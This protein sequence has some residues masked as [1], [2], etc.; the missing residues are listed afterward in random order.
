MKK[1]FGPLTIAA[2]IGFIS[3]ESQAKGNMSGA[4]G[5]GYAFTSRHTALSVN[6][7][8]LTSGDSPMSLYG[9]YSFGNTFDETSDDIIPAAFTGTSGKVG[10]GVATSYPLAD[11]SDP[12]YSGGLGFLLGTLSLGFSVD[13][14]SDTVLNSGLQL[15]LGSMRLGFV[16]NNLTNADS[17]SFGVGLGFG[18]GPAQ[19]EVSWTQNL[20]MDPMFA[21]LGFG[22]AYNATPLSF[23]ARY[24]AAYF[25]D[26]FM[27]GDG[28]LQTGVEL[29]LG[30]SLALSAIVG[31]S[32]AADS[33]A[34]SYLV[35]ARAKF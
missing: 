20:P 24:D 12:T 14:V 35:G 3:L 28:A 10:Y 17:G 27:F 31:Y 7:A 19:F 11:G 2:T 6:P 32:L 9:A 30:K 4:F 5:T 33:D 13:Y 23:L 29:G 16:F 22:F 18:S 25:N 26:E 21:S 34:I 15:D 8:G 1:I